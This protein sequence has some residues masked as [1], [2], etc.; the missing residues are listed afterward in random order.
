[1]C[2]RVFSPQNLIKGRLKSCVEAKP[3]MTA[4]QERLR[5]FCPPQ[6]LDKSYNQ[7]NYNVEC[8]FT[9]WMKTR[10]CLSLPWVW[11]ICWE[12]VCLLVTLAFTIQSYFRLS[13]LWVYSIL[14]VHY[15]KFISV[16]IQRELTA[17]ETPSVS[18]NSPTLHC[19]LSLWRGI[20][21][22]QLYM[23][24]AKFRVTDVSQCNMPM[25]FYF[26]GISNRHTE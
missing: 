14:Y 22:V 20:F 5:E 7:S 13:M 23:P 12:T 2:E 16:K 15:C 10:V 18:M 11:C 19:H 3:L 8:H 4:L 26:V 17:F 9:D 24:A 6:C 25:L 1:M 21:I